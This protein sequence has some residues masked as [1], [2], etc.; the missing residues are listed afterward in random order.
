[1]RLRAV[2]LLLLAAGWLAGQTA[3][4]WLNRG[5]QAFKNAQYPEAVA[6]FQRAVELDASNPTPRLYLATAY[7]QQY[8]PDA[9]SRENQDL[10]RNA[11]AV[12]LSVLDLDPANKV[13]LSS[14]AS[15]SLNQK[16]WDE[17]S[18]WYRRV[19][20]VDPRDRDAYYSQ[21]FIAWSRWFPAYRT[22]R[23][24]AGMKPEDPGPIPDPAA[25]A[26][27]RGQ[28]WQLLDDG[29]RDLEQA[30]ALD[31]EHDDAMAYMN[32]LIRE[33]ADLLDTAEE[34]RRDVAE[35]D[36][37]VNKALETKRA[38]A[39]RGQG[40]V[41]PRPPPPPRLAA[42]SGGGDRASNAPRASLV[43]LNLDGS[44]TPRVKPDPVY[45][46]LALQA[47]IQGTVY[48]QLVI[49]K[50]GR[51]KNITVVQ[52]HPLLVIA[53]LDA[54][55]QYEYTPILSNGEPVEVTT[56]VAIAFTLR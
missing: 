8:I 18:A 6:A 21:G 3:Q 17:A 37:W 4:E 10:A 33:R 28:W 44:Q 40:M 45:P 30:L 20:A 55:K 11:E 29:M 26:V 36:R 52:G 24:Q 41:P 53:A 48:L 43:S 38:K 1:M 32:L 49:G 56:Q 23:M 13:A 9:E 47:G 5:V 50:D 14:L 22:A 46:P 16:K 2:V 35:A 12:F 39:Q 42:G 15:L 54:A 25:R 34:Y 27:L 51:V 31:P 7:M 19:L